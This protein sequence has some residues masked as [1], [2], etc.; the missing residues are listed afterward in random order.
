[1]QEHMSFKPNP[2]LERDLKKSIIKNLKMK[3]VSEDKGIVKGRTTFRNWE[4]L[5]GFLK[6]L[7]NVNVEAIKD[8]AIKE[9]GSPPEWFVKKYPKFS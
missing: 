1:M 9:F 6:K 2:N 3:N 5:D 8:S 7:E 4:E